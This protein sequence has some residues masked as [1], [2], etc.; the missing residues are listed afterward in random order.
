M[1]HTTNGAPV[2]VEQCDRERAG[3]LY[4]RAHPFDPC[5]PPKTVARKMREGK[6]DDG[7]YV[8]DFARHRLAALASAPAGDGLVEAAFKEGIATGYQ[9]GK[10][11][12]NTTDEWHAAWLA[13]DASV[14]AALAR[15]RAAVGEQQVLDELIVQFGREGIALTQEIYAPVARAILALQSPPAKVEGE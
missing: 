8:Q 12:E 14:A 5:C 4:E 7:Q 3:D 9:C 13:S 10:A 11:D 15:P 6:L 1:T 2:T